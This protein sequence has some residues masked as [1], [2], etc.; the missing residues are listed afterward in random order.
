MTKTLR[1]IIKFEWMT[2]IA[3]MAVCLI[4]VFAIYLSGSNAS[5]FM[6][7]VAKK[8]AQTYFPINIIDGIFWIWG[9]VTLEYTKGDVIRDDL[10]NEN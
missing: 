6:D 3:L 7:E 10:I 9:L 8:L 5:T 2:G 1:K 4:I